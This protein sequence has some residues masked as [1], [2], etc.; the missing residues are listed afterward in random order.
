MSTNDVLPLNKPII[1]LKDVLKQ[2]NKHQKALLLQQQHHQ[3]Q[4]HT[5]ASQEA[6]S[7]LQQQQNTSNATSV[8]QKPAHKHVINDETKLKIQ[9]IID[10]Y[11]L[12][13]LNT[14]SSNIISSSR[15]G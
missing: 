13:C 8:T 12:E 14:S 9:Q 2:D 7:A 4:Q 5:K 15:I 10:D 1:P 11:L 6:A 3:Q